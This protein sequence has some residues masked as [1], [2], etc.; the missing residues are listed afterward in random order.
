[1]KRT[2][3]SVLISTITLM[4]L[5]CEDKAA[6][7]RAASQAA[8]EQTDRVRAAVEAERARLAQV[9]ADKE[10]RAREA[11][12]NDYPS[13]AKPLVAELR[14]TIDFISVGMTYDEYRVRVEKI[15]DALDVFRQNKTTA[16]KPSA[17]HFTRCSKGLVK[18]LDV[19]E[20]EVQRLEANAKIGVR[21][22]LTTSAMKRE[23]REL[24]EAA[25]AEYLAGVV[26]MDGG[27]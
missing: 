18:A 19:W 6:T 27:S 14:K 16:G 8:A 1:M 5:A 10:E 23:R 13:V 21:E 7:Q 4:G 15:I 3:F 12:R 20:S 25:A 26:K 11:K 22:D 2:I 24:W 9:E 17:E